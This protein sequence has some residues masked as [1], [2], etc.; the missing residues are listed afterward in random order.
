M[1]R[2]CNYLS[3]YYGKHNVDS[4]QVFGSV[5]IV[6]ESGNPRYLIYAP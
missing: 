2:D 5:N 3:A 4:I 6:D 1:Q